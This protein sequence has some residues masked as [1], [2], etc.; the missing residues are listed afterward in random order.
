MPNCTQ[1]FYHFLAAC[2]GNWRNT[3]HI[4]CAAC[5]DNCACTDHLL[6]VDVEGK[7]VLMDVGQFRQLSGEDIDP[8]EC[9]GQLDRQAFEDIFKNFLL[10]ALPA[11]RP[12]VLW[13]LAPPD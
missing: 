11:P 5:P 8:S 13:Q 6:A 2:G 3:I 4:T 12:C 9:R 10:W 1:K 7:P